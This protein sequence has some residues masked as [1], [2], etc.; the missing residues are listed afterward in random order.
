M[1]KKIFNPVL[2]MNLEKEATVTLIPY[3]DT[4]KIIVKSQNFNFSYECEE[5]DMDKEYTL[6]L[7]SFQK[8]LNEVSGKINFKINRGK[9]IDE[10]GQDLTV[11][12]ETEEQNFLI[13]FEEKELFI[14][15]A[16]IQNLSR[17]QNVR[18]KLALYPALGDLVIANTKNGV[19]FNSS[20]GM[21]VLQTRIDC[22]LKLQYTYL[23]PFELMKNTNLKKLK[24]TK[25][26]E[27]SKIIFREEGNYLYIKN[28]IDN[29]KNYYKNISWTVKLTKTDAILENFDNYNFNKECSF[30]IDENVDYKKI[31]KLVTQKNKT[32]GGTGK[33]Y[34]VSYKV[35]DGYLLDGENKIMKLSSD[36]PNIEII[37]GYDFMAI[38]N[39]NYE[40]DYYKSNKGFFAIESNKQRLIMKL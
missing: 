11:L 12:E 16:L 28:I 21:S 2:N 34:N 27:D 37:N 10:N 24:I 4:I 30:K 5:T 3:K 32:I 13:K 18:M 36:I 40:F 20:N 15:T 39:D 7:L 8:A 6:N 26:D 22:N 35:A 23:C 33:K 9:V 29:S 14:K 25:A 38:F 31:G 17:H 1:K 19:A